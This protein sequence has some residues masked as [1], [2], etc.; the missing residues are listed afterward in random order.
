MFF[1]GLPNPESLI[2]M[3]DE[4]LPFS[5]LTPKFPLFLKH[6]PTDK[7][8]VILRISVD[9]LKPKL[10]FTKNTKQGVTIELNLRL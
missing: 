9:W 10:F 2:L 8:F 3:R 5:K 1:K 6:K 7:V 4:E